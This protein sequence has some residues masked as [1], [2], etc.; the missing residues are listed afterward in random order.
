LD[1][2]LSEFYARCHECSQSS[3]WHITV[4]L[5]RNKELLQFLKAEK[6]PGG[7]NHKRLKNVYRAATAGRSTAGCCVKHKTRS[8]KK[9]RPS[10]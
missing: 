5:I 3:K 2:K 8:E 1:K 4:K 6:K 7:D 10:Q 9:F